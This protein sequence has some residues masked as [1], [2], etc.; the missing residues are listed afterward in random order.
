MEHP[1][2]TVRQAGHSRLYHYEK[3]RPE[4]LSTTLRE[5]KVHCSNPA[6]L[7]DPWDCRPWYDNSI[8]E[9]DEIDALISWGR[10]FPQPGIPPRQPTQFEARLRT[11]AITSVRL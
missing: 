5:Q 4:W 8:T 6:N 2:R 9:P 3:F 1:H 11:D 10:Q 7:N